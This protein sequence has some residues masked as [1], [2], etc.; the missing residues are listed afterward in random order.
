MSTV[1]HGPCSRIEAFPAKLVPNGYLTHPCSAPLLHVHKN[2]VPGSGLLTDLY[3]KI[4]AVC[5][6]QL[7]FASSSGF[8][9]G[10]KK[11]TLSG[12]FGEYNQKWTES[13][14]RWKDAEH[15]NDL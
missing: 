4:W 14:K 11:A 15:L 13:V 5:R 12:P 8:S 1:S 10:K 7:D 6:R 3:R 9:H 2:Y